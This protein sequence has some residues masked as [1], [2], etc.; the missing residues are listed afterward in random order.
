MK[1]L[2]VTLVLFVAALCLFTGCL[3]KTDETEDGTQQPDPPAA[4]TGN[5]VTAEEW[6]SAFNKSILSD[7]VCE[8]T[9]QGA[10]DST[11]VIRLAAKEE[12]GK[13]V[14]HLK[15]TMSTRAAPARNEEIWI[16]D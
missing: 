4:V 10:N 11:A 5:T 14:Y 6:D 15:N 16:C 1:K 13:M 9:G 2:L 3:E 8:V 12:D 7:I